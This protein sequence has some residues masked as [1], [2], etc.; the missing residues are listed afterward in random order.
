[1]KMYR[2]LGMQPKRRKTQISVTNE[3]TGDMLAVTG[4]DVESRD[5]DARILTITS[6]V[7]K[8]FGKAADI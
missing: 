7:V 5:K 2:I 6:N 3:L 1:M 8:D 4:Y